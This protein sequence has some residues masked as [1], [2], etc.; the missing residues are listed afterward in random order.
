MPIQ[1]RLLHEADLKREKRERMKRELELLQMQ[2]C[3]FQPNLV[4]NNGSASARHRNATGLIN[5]NKY[6]QNAP[7]H[8]RVGSIQKNKNERL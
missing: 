1:D 2:E 4:S 8:E 3:S 6:G 5:K 7:I